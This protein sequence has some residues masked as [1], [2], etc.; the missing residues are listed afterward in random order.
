MKTGPIVAC[1]MAVASI[2]GGPLRAATPP[3]SGTLSIEATESAPDVAASIPAFI[4]AVSDALTTRGFNLLEEP[5]H[6]AFVVEIGVTRDQVGT[7][8]AK[9]PPS[10]SQ[11]LPGASPA[12]GVGVVV[13]F[14]TGKSTLVPLQRTRLDMRIRKRGEDAITWQGAAVTVRAA[15]TAKGMDK[16]VAADLTQAILRAYPAQPADVIGV[17]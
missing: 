1:A 7:A 3:T 2:W 14:S 4:E 17:P 6:A 10:R 16:A 9:V 15:R 13:P 12:V 5:G 8:S 11:I